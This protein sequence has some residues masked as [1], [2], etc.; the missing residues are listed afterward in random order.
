[1]FVLAS[2]GWP[3][4]CYC[5]G[6]HTRPWGPGASSLGAG[7]GTSSKSR[8]SAC[9]RCSPTPALTLLS[10]PSKCLKHC[11]PFLGDIS[12]SIRLGAPRG[13]GHS[14][15]WTSA[16]LTLTSFRSLLR[17]ALLGEP[18]LANPLETAPDTPVFLH[19]SC[20]QLTPV[21][22]TP[23]P[24][25]NQQVCQFLDSRDFCL[26]CAPRAPCP[27]QRPADGRGSKHA[28]VS[29]SAALLGTTVHRA[30]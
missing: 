2:P 17:S 11:S 28:C 12:S 29:V 27:R 9:P 19:S 14:H 25:C 7:R 16:R 5:S 1:M 24:C 18:C 10:G 8:P 20:G 15:L 6:N 23:S 4:P 21:W 30:S 22:F 26:F 13:S 3:R